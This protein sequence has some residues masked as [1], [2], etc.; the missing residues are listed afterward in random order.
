MKQAK[1]FIKEN[2]KQIIWLV[3]IIIVAWFAIE[4]ISNW[5]AFLNGF[6]EGI[7]Q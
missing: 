1:T 6:N 2:R 3:V 7:N 5:A 4:L